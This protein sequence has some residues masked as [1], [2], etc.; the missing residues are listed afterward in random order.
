[1]GS[2]AI[3]GSKLQD[4]GNK[5]ISLFFTTRSLTGQQKRWKILGSLQVI[6]LELV[7]VTNW[8]GLKRMRVQLYLELLCLEELQVS[9]NLFNLK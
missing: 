5:M 7:T 3:K 1:M 2:F 8:A 9:N 4:Q 6:L